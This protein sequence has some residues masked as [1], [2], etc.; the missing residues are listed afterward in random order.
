MTLEGSTGGVAA[1]GGGEVEPRL[2]WHHGSRGAAGVVTWMP[3]SDIAR[4]RCSECRRSYCPSP[5][6]GKAQKVCGPACRTARNRRL[7]RRRRA[8]DPV[9]HR[10]LERARQRKWREGR[11]GR[12]ASSAGETA[13]PTGG[14][15]APPSAENPAQ[16]LKVALEKVDE[17]VEASR[18]TLRGVLDEI[19][20]TCGCSCGTGREVAV[21][22][23][24]RHV[25]IVDSGD[26]SGKPQGS[27][28]GCHAQG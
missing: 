24:T 21:A 19:R 2:S 26:C 9:R 5:K 25:D 27:G 12:S 22:P 15:H 13:A 16:L 6:A 20:R 14:S 8:R 23:V 11:K 18:A 17:S 28:T 7:A 10:A 1:G 3:N 4:R